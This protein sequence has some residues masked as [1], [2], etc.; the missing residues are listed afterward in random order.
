VRRDEGA[1]D[2]RRSLAISQ[3]LLGTR[4]VVVSHHT[5]CGLQTF[6]NA[7]LRARRRTALGADAAGIDFLPFGDVEASVRQDVAAI[8]GSPLVPRDVAVSGFVYDVRT[9]RLHAVP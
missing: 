2:A 9:G 4:E 3:Q 7:E 1:A 8:R 6:T 5:D